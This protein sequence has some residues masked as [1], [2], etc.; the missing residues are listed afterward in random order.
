MARRGTTVRAATLYALLKPMIGPVQDGKKFLV[1]LKSEVY[2]IVDKGRLKF[3][4]SFVHLGSMVRA[5][6]MD[7]PRY[8]IVPDEGGGFTYNE[9]D[10][11]N[12]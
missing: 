4:G 10:E 7:F 6:S 9:H 3:L 1:T 5:R 8:D 2:L 12:D 11:D